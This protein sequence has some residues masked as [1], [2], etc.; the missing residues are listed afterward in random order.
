VTIYGEV[1]TTNHITTPMG[2]KTWLP[3]TTEEMSPKDA[4]EFCAQLG[5]RL[6]TFA[7]FFEANQE[8]IDGFTK[9]LNPTRH[10]YTNKITEGDPNYIL[11]EHAEIYG[12]ERYKRGPFVGSVDGYTSV[13]DVSSLSEG[14]YYQTNTGNVRCIKE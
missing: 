7:E 9:T 14:G 2:T 5:G 8:D 4:I 10:S 1:I 3:A 6:P 12:I 13:K 11:D